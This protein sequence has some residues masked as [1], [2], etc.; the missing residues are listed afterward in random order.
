MRENNKFW[1]EEYAKAKGKVSIGESNAKVVKMKEVAI[2]AD[3]S[4]QNKVHFPE[5]WRRK[6][7]KESVLKELKESVNSKVLHTDEY[8]KYRA[9]LFLSGCTMVRVAIID[10]LWFCEIH[11]EK[12][13]GL[14]MIKEIRTQYLPDDMVFAMILP[15]RSTPT[16]SNLVTLYQIPGELK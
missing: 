14:P 16:A 8:G 9:G 1:E 13:I 7:L 5:F 4:T 15:P 6:K 11:S 3:K 2:I 10:E 12:Q